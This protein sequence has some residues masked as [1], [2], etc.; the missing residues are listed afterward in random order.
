MSTSLGILNISGPVCSIPSK[1]VTRFQS[2]VSLGDLRK[3]DGVRKE[4]DSV[5][6]RIP[7]ALKEDTETPTGD[8]KS[9]RRA[10]KRGG[11]TKYAVEKHPKRR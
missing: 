4:C 3:K 11:A 5:R 8:Q 7:G 6:E 2:V 9:G 10:E 1:T